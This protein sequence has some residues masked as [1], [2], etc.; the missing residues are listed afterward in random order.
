MV[1]IAIKANE[2]GII[3]HKINIGISVG[4]ELLIQIVSSVKIVDLLII[5]P[6]LT[7]ALLGL[8][9]I[10]FK[11]GVDISNKDMSLSGTIYK[12]VCSFCIA[13]ITIYQM[14]ENSRTVLLIHAIVVVVIEVIAIF[15]IKYRYKI[16]NALKNKGRKK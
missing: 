16:L 6:L 11:I 13:G 2:K 8:L 5:F 14:Y 15:V 9:F 1:V 10:Q 3:L 7:L 12:Y 4:L